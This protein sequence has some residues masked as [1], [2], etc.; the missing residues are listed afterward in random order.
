VS[1]FTKTSKLTHDQMA[2]SASVHVVCL[3]ASHHLLKVV[4]FLLDRP[5]PWSEYV[6]FTMMGKYCMKC[7][8]SPD[9]M[10]CNVIRI[11]AEIAGSA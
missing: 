10:R 5:L 2:F 8:L 9:V 7:Y 4:G 6:T 3:L 11:V 1:L